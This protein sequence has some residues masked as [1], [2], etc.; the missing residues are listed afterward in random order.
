MEE[1]NC[2]IWIVL[3]PLQ[4]GS[5]VGHKERRRHLRRGGQ[6]LEEE[7][8]ALLKPD[9]HGAHGFVG[10]GSDPEL[11]VGAV[12]NFKELKRENKPLVL[13]IIE[14]LRKL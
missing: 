1:G 6:A 5:Q 12:V 11:L 2:G 9:V 8:V 7:L 10:E 4:S 13:L 3:D 14:A